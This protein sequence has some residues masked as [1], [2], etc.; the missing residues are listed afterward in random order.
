MFFVSALAQPNYHS[1]NNNLRI[2]ITGTL[3][4]HALL[5]VLLAW[6]FAQEAA[7]KLWQQ[8]NKPPK[9]KEV[10]LIFPEQLMPPP[11]VVKPKPPPPP[12]Q[13]PEVYMRTSQN[14]EADSAPKN[15]AF[16][17]D[18]NTKAS[19]KMAPS[20]DGT[21]PLPSMNGL[22][23]PTREL[24]DRDNHDG[25]LKDDARPKSPERSIPMMQP[26][27]PQPPAPAAPKTEMKPQQMASQ[28]QAAQPQP[29]PQQTAK[30]KP[31]TTPL[32]KMMEEADKELAK[33]DKNL[34][35]IEVKKPDAMQKKPDAPPKPEPKP[36]PAPTPKPEMAQQT[37]PESMP[38]KP[39]PKALPVLDDEVITRTTP[40]QAPNSFT[41]FTRRS[42][43]KGTISNRGTED[44]VDAEATPKGRYIRQ[45]T[46]QVEKKWHIYRLLR[47][48]GVTYGSLQVV[49]YVN[50]Q[51]KVEDLRIVNDKESNPILTGFTLQAIRDADI[52]PMPAD[53]IPSLPMNDQ[54]RLKVEYNVLI[55]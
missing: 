4:V 39:V 30:A 15:A 27:P 53:V 35:P 2:A 9:E 26:Q 28:P 31:D 33:V 25:D 41:P 13:K 18:R 16:I 6:L 40:N 37:P 32:T 29:Q 22:K 48:D 10:T 21:E 50:K 11:E 23:L 47:R 20:P 1:S 54:E 12:P 34:L 49:F 45:V 36:E 38:Q 43:T 3:V 51:G 8:A 55:Y 17:A 42:Q 5:F 46:G 24:A 19:T 44:A 14:Q 52:P 7:H